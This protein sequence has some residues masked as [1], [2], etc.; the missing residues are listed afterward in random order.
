MVSFLIAAKNN[1]TLTKKWQEICSKEKI[2]K[3]DINLIEPEKTMGIGE[4]R[5]AW[6]K[7]FLKPFKSEKKAIILNAFL[8]ITTEAQNALLK[9]L[10]EPPNNTIIIVLVSDLETVLPTIISRCKVIN[11]NQ[12]INITEEERKEYEKT[13]DKLLQ[14]TIGEKLKLAETFGKTSKEGEIFTEKIILVIREKIL[15]E[16]SR[17]ELLKILKEFERANKILKTTNANSRLILENLFFS[18]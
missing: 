3:F 6:K 15:K 1:D 16:E 8:G 5:G 2:D 9:S 18:I 4:I 11:L 10:E 7:L 17:G 14:A 12:G 13:I